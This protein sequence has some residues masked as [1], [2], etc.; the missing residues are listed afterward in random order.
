[1]IL[2]FPRSVRQE[3]VLV[4]CYSD[5][6]FVNHKANIYEGEQTNEPKAFFRPAVERKHAQRA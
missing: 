2:V 1:L 5:G 3:R 4:F 6:V